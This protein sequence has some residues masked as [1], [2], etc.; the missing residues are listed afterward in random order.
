MLRN[1]PLMSEVNRLNILL[2]A[3]LAFQAGVFNIGGFLACHRFVSHVTGFATFFGYDLSEGRLWAAFGIIL[4]PVFFLIG[5]MISG[6]LID[7]RIRTRR[8]PLY[9]IAFGLVFILTLGVWIAG[10]GKV[11][12]PFGAPVSSLTDYVL[13]SLLCL[14]CGIQNGTV[15]IVSRSVVRTTHLTG[16]T[17]DLGIGL[18]RLAHGVGTEGRRSEETLANIMRISI[19]FGFVLGSGIGGLLFD[20]THYWGFILPTVTSALFFLMAALY[21]QAFLQTK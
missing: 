9:H 3:I 4:V 11:F 10:V 5:S 18:V 14:I 8:E 15:A 2:W 1:R 17:T 19:I 21:R 12:G 7:V 6:E 13:L 16:I 20:L